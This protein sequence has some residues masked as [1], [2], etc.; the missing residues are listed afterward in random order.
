VRQVPTVAPLLTVG[1][2]RRVHPSPISPSYYLTVSNA[3]LG[4]A[5][6][7]R[8]STLY[9][10]ETLTAAGNTLPAICPG[11]TEA[12]AIDVRKDGSREF[13]FDQLV[14]RYEDVFGNRYSTEYKLFNSTCKD[15]VWRRPWVGK[16]FDVP[17]PLHDSADPPSWGSNGREYVDAAN[18]R[19]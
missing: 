7:P 19:L 16:D 5:C 15:H 3:G 18:G 6:N 10:G 1:I 12:T 13:H 4:T 8:L 14:I 2:E 9:N 17:K 11:H